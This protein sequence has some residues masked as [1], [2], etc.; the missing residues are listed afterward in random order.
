MSE[1]IIL[2]AVTEGYDRL[3]LCLTFESLLTYIKKIENSLSEEKKVKRVLFDQLLITGNSDN[4]FMSCEFS[5]G[6][7]DFKSAKIVNPSEI[8]RKKTV[9][10]LH[11][12]Y[13]YVEHS[14]LTTEQCQKIKDKIAF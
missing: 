10:W 8:Y 11:E 6:K 13:S 9:E 4:R 5:K 12:N 14:I 3:V 2:D 1:Y 7:M